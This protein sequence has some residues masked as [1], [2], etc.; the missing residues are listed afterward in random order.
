MLN[1]MLGARLM[2][3][4]YSERQ[5]F[6]RMVEFWTDHFNIPIGDLLSYK[7]VDD[8]EVIRRHAMGSFRDLLFASAR[9]AAMLYYLNNDSSTAEHPN[10]NY[11]REIMELHTLGVDGGYTESDVINVARALTGFTVHN[12]EFYF[13]PNIHDQGEKYIL[14]ARF[15]AGRGIEDG[16][17][18]LDLLANHPSTARFVC[19]KLCRR[20]LG[21]NP[22]PS[23]VDSAASV[24]TQTRGSIRDVLRHILTSEEFMASEGQKFR[25]PFEYL[26]AILRVLDPGLQ[27][28]NPSDLVWSLEALGQVPFFW[29]PPNGYP[30]VSGAWI[31]TNGLLHRWN[32]AMNIALSGDGY[33]SGAA[34]DV[35][36]VVPPQPTAG[37]LV[38][39]ASERILG[40]ILPEP[41]RQ[42]MISYV[43]S[44]A[45]TPIDASRYHSRAPILIGLLLASPYFQWS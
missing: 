40:M 36:A 21:D 28:Q 6:E 7:I 30:D 18:V 24:F 35:R 4:V 38:D 2:R 19:F 29:H 39:A 15:P 5:L 9:S 8:R 20:F 16:L 33:L 10:E 11:A 14:G 27:I 44:S 3:A 32:L 42:T 45:D 37:A 23:I 43:A 25:R 22:P 17:Q 1:T 31:N 13:D 12:G 26:V 34:L 41:D